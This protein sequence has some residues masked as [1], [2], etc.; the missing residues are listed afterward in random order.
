M[1]PLETTKQHEQSNAPAA[2]SAGQAHA[3]RSQWL[4][5]LVLSAVVL[6]LYWMVVVKLVGQWWTDANYSHGFVIVGFSGYLA[7]S[8]RNEL[9]TV[10]ARPTWFGLVA[11]LAAIALLFLGL[12]GAEYFL[13]RISLL[14]AIVGLLLFLRGWPTAKALA[15]PLAA[16]LLMIPLPTIVYNQI[17]FPLQLLASK[18]ATWSLQV[19][20]IVPVLREGNVL[21]LPSGPLEVAEACSGIR[22]LMSLL[23]V[24]VM[25]GYFSEPNKWIRTVICLSIVPIAVLSNSARVVFAAL[26]AEFLGEAAVE[27]M[28]HTLSGIFL[29]LVATML[30]VGFHGV[31]RSFVRNRVSQEA[32]A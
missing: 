16:L 27:G 11:I 10:P 3:A 17:V 13:T 18:F 5:L 25:Y 26:S 20:H 4:P 32:G 6:A 21:V 1:T 23:A 19:S 30:M 14:L 8:R 31:V 7:W 12:L 15:F 9:K 24:S 29:F 2:A 22:S 28:T